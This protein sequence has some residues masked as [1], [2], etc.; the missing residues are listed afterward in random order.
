MPSLSIP[1]RRRFVQSGDVWLHVVE[2]GPTDGDPVVLLH[3][4][5]EFWYGWRQQIPALAEAGYRVV[6]PDQ[7]GYHRS[8]APPEISAYDLPHLVNDVR[9]VIGSTG[10]NR[11]HVIGHDWGAAVAWALAAWHPEAV[12]RLAILNVPHLDVFRRTLR[13]SP[14]QLLRSVYILLFQIPR[15]PEWLLSRADHVLLTRL[16]TASGR[17]DTFAAEDLEVYRSA[18]RRPG[19]LRGMLNWYRAAARRAVSGASP[20][21]RIDPP[22]LVLWGV[23][24]VALSASMARP[25][26]D[27][28]RDGRLE[29]I[30]GATHWVQHDAPD[31]V[32]RL[33]LEHLGG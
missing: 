20:L 8:D 28:C 29:T 31:R 27:L 21:G 23:H 11:A 7:R 19:R 24:D 3:G 10:S 25:S 15:L 32:N 6:V 9:A 26:A 14:A 13:S 22:T 5:P 1:T 17:R 16:L 33:L 12:R 30:D 18:W 4:F 2:A